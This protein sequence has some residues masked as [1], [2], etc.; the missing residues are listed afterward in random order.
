MT[1]KINDG[2]AAYPVATIDGYTQYGMSLRDWFAV[3]AL[4]GLLASGGMPRTA[5]EP[6]APD[7][8]AEQAYFLADAMLKARNTQGE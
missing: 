2:G 3:F 7:H 1:S 6:I 8:A 5:W 4:Q